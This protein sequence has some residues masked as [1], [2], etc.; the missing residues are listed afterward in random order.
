VA[1]ADTRLAHH[2]RPGRTAPRSPAAVAGL[3][4]CSPKCG[5]SPSSPGPSSVSPCWH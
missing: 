5:V 4:G 2:P 1:Q 3:L